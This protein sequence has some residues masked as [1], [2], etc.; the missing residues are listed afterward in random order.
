M[1]LRMSQSTGHSQNQGKCTSDSIQMYLLM[2]RGG[3][4]G[5]GSVGL[6]EVY[7]VGGGKIMMNY[8]NAAEVREL[9]GM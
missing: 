4:G 5:R 2:R 3:R 1:Y 8:C 7:G 6:K 9:D